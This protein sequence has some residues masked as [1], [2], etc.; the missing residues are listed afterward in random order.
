MAAY[1]PERSTGRTHSRPAPLLACPTVRSTA[2]VC[3]D[4]VPVGVD[5][6]IN[7]TE[8]VDLITAEGN[9]FRALEYLEHPRTT[10]A[11]PLPLHMVYRLAI[12]AVKALLDSMR[13]IPT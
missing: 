11:M 12:R 8:T 9:V 3:M 5:P 6:V 10:A 4:P 13:K 7:D 2:W 1:P